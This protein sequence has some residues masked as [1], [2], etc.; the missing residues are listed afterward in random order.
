MKIKVIIPNSGMD[1]ETLDS[2]EK[3]LSAALSAETL[4]SVD[5]ISSGPTSIESNSDEVIA[6]AEVLRL[7][8]KA[9]RDGFDAVVIYCY[10]DPAIDAVRENVSIPV[11]GPGEVSLAVADMLSERFAVVTTIRD[12]ICRT[13]RRLMK[14]SVARKKMKAVLSL[15][16]PVEELRDDPAVTM[17]YLDRLCEKAV[18]EYDIDTLVLGCLG[19]AQYG[20]ALEKKYGVKVL[21]PAFLAIG[22]AEYAARLGLVPSRLAYPEYKKGAQNGLL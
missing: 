1:R 7:C 2:R 12:N 22:Y 6:G 8:I 9:E 10:S 19:M 18:R 20:D 3:M 13:E 21:D 14:S 4:I 17:E 11:I 5:C 16:I 15:D